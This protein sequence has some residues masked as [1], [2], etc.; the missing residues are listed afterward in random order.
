MKTRILPLVLLFFTVFCVQAQDF[1]YGSVAMSELTMTKYDRDTSANA[2]VLKEFGEAFISDADYHLIFKYHVRIKILNKNG[3]DQ[4]EI[5]IPLHKQGNNRIERIVS[6]KASSFNL[7]NDKIREVELEEKNIFNEDRNK[8]YSVKKFAIP[9]VRVGSVIE[10]AYTMDSPFVFNFR[11]WEFQ[12]EIPKVQSE[13]WASIPGI[14][15]YNITLRGYQKL[16]KNESNIIRGCL[17]SG[18]SRDGGFSADCGQMKYAMRNIPAFVEEDYMTAKKNFISSIHF[19]LS[20]I[21]HPTG[22]V[23]KVT[24]EW[25]DAEQELR[26]ENRFGAQLR[27]GKE[28]GEEVKKLI[29]G[30]TDELTKAKKVYEFIKERYLWNDTYGKYS[31][32][33]I[34]K[35]F[36]ER[37]GNVGDIN[38]S[39]IAALRFAGLDVEPVILSTRANGQVIELHPVLSGFNYVVAKVNIGEKVYLADA[40]VKFHPFGMLPQRCLNGKGRVIGERNSYWIDL[41]P[42]DVAKRIAML[43]L[44]LGADGVMRGSLQTTYSGYDA[45][46]KRAEIAGFQS[47]EDYVNKLKN[48]HH[49]IQINSCELE[50]LKDIEKSVVQKLDIEIKAFD[51]LET[52]N[53][54][55]SPFIL[56]KWPENP[57][58]SRERLYPVDFA[59]PVEHLTV[60]NLEYPTEFELVNLPDKVGLHLPNSGGRFLFEVTNLDNKLTLNNSLSIRKTVYTSTEYHFLKELFSRIIQIQNGEL[61]FK[62][63]T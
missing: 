61:V 63:K 38:L 4:S 59:F 55:V 15:L 58:K 13:Y 7:E 45:V 39:L 16:T 5:H 11:S 46:R 9:N 14:Y 2:V 47:E 19:E 21:R 1:P 42:T 43:S 22:G 41:K 44:K 40:T 52:A 8:F 31:E 26:Q 24:K 18:N 23:D 49:E 62:K 53:F 32:F 36:D 48:T 20:E 10:L 28:I 56:D 60:F 3:L 51:D 25:K 33:G 27:R 29:A 54:L 37:K 6:I 17:G 30:E 57:F 50:N 35:A 12:S 34:K